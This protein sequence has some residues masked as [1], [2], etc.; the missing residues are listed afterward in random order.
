MPSF[1]GYMAYSSLILL[2]VF[3]LLTLLFFL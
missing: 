3:G 2:P 1:F